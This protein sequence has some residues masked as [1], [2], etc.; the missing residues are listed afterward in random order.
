MIFEAKKVLEIFAEYENE[1]FNK[2]IKILMQ[3]EPAS[4]D[5]RDARDRLKDITAAQVMAARE[6][7]D[8]FNIPEIKA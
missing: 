1:I 7:R 6:L 2:H 4:M 8:R 3:R 5:K